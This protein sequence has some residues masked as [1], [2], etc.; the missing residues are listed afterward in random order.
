[1]KFNFQCGG[2]VASRS[3]RFETR[4]DAVEEINKK[5]GKYLEKPLE[6]EFYDGLPSTLKEIETNF[7]I[8]GE[9][10]EKESEENV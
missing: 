8:N 5:F 1:M 6:V 7:D 4:Q 2:T 3:N 10:V 9:N